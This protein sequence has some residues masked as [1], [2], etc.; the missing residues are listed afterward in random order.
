MPSMTTGLTS[1]ATKASS[2]RLSAASRRVHILSTDGTTTP[3]G[4]TG[5]LSGILARPAG[6]LLCLPRCSSLFAGRGLRNSTLLVANHLGGGVIGRRSGTAG[7]SVARGFRRSGV[8]RSSRRLWFALLGFGLLPAAGSGA[9]RRHGR[10]SGPNELNPKSGDQLHCC[11]LPGSHKKH[12]LRYSRC[13]R[14][15]PTQGGLPDDQSGSAV[16]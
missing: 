11:L 14:R 2:A 16:A 5:R 9:C 10:R 3:V 13:P 15:R 7:R 4:S 1:S 8:L 12:L 6:I